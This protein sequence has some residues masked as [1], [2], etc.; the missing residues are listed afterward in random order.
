MNERILGAP[1]SR[2]DGALK[3]RGAAKYAVE[4]AMERLCHAVMVRSTIAAGAIT[5]ID[6]A[7]ARSMPGGT[8]RP[9]T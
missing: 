1:L 4:F 2:V 5:A 3:V 8:R 6:S 9:V 7:A